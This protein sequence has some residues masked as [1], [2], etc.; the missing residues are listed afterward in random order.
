[1]F[2][3]V[4]GALPGYV[5]A[6]DEAGVYVNLFLGSQ[7]SVSLN[8]TR[9]L[10]RQTTRY[11]WDVQVR[12]SVESER[13]TQFAVNLRLPAWCAEP[14]VKVNGH[15]VD[16]LNPVRGYARLTRLWGP[17]D[18]VELSLPMP[19]QRVKANP[20]VEADVGRVA[21][22]RGPLVYCLEATDNAGPVRNL[23]LPP[24]EPLRAEFRAD[25]LSGITVI[26]GSA[27][28]LEPGNWPDTLYLPSAKVPAGAPVEFTA[29]PYYANANRQPAE[30][31]VWMAEG[32]SMPGH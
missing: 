32:A 18:V 30:M 31:S 26:Q 20:K 6:Q 21:L 23:V 14:R 25:L 2:L 3:K 28:T 9:V 24:Q 29:I 19:V 12:L 4:M 1:M 17:G 11:P 27:R 7:A 10:L 8:G 22:Q 16:A 15:A 13:K 5:Y